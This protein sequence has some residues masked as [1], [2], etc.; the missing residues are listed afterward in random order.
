MNKKVFLP[1][2]SLLG[3]ITSCGSKER[4]YVFIT[5]EEERVSFLRSKLDEKFPNYD[6][7]LQSIGTGKLV[8]KLMA[9][10]KKTSCD[11]FFDLE[12]LNAE[13]IIS[14]NSDLF[15]DL[16]DDEYDFSRYDE[17]VLQYRN[18]HT[19]YA[20]I[21]K[22]Y[23]AVLINNNVLDK[24]G[25][26]APTTYTDLLDPKYKG[27]IEMPDPNSSGTGY[28]IYSGLISLYGETE[29][30]NY[31]KSLKNNVLEFTTSGSTP[32]KDVE[33]GNIGVGFGML[34]Q[35]VEYANKPG[36][37]HLS[38]KVLDD[39]APYTY[40]T[41]GMI[42]HA[43]IRPA[44]KE[45]FDYFYNELNRLQV[46]KFV[47]NKIYKDQLP[48]DIPNYP[49][50]FEEINMGDHIYDFEYKLDLLDKWVA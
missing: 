7:V 47:P 40:F 34:W 27:L 32:L 38:V 35:C 4:I 22:T 24:K 8:S 15:Y 16:V 36:N 5:S 25:I 48:T 50:N 41:M 1:L 46:D 2:I 18:R 31:F 33:S 49:T 30:L 23:G 17:A 11:I 6:V 39:K 13:R 14:S 3:G 10:G 37:E 44:V 21:Q 28:S 20:V 43:Q 12:V 26:A 42:N 45:V 29:G 19:K 9:E